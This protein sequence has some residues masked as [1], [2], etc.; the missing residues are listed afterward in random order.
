MFQNVQV[1]LENEKAIC[2]YFF[3]NLFPS[4]TWKTQLIRKIELFISVWLKRL[5]NQL[6]SNPNSICTL[7]WFYFQAILFH[8]LTTYLNNPIFVTNQEVWKQ[9]M[10]FWQFHCHEMSLNF[11][12]NQFLWI[13]DLYN[14][15][16]K[17][18]FSWKLAERR[19]VYLI[20]TLWGELKIN[21]NY[22]KFWSSLQYYFI[23]RKLIWHT[24]LKYHIVTL[25]I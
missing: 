1:R 11:T 14:L 23:H 8:G 4:N 15:S 25:F 12:W 24:T 7:R 20:I 19:I 2:E 16:T 22:K 5:Y 17:L 3:V 18:N 10:L 6:D 13:L 21:K 9:C